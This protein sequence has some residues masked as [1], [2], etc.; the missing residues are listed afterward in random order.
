MVCVVLTL[1]LIKCLFG[2]SKTCWWWY[3][4]LQ[5]IR[6]AGTGGS[7]QIILGQTKTDLILQVYL[8]LV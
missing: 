3:T 8:I 7:G 5:K 6:T 1:V 2:V 4:G